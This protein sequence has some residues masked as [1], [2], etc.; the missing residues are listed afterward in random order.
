MGKV[1]TWLL[2]DSP[3]TRLQAQLGRV[4]RDVSALL[5]DPIAST[6]L[7]I[8][9]LM[10]GEALLATFLPV[11]N[12][13]FQALGDRLQPPS[14]AH[15]FGTDT[16]GRDIFSRVLS[17]ARPT[18]S[19]VACVLAIVL[20]FGVLV[21]ITA[22]IFERLDAP[23]MRLCDVFMAF[24]R[25]VLAIAVAVT[26]GPG[27]S[28]AIIAIAL[29]GWPS[30]ARIARAEAVA[31]RRAEFVQAAQV[32]GASP[33]RI[34]FTHILP[35]CLPSAI[36]RATLDASSIIL[37][38]SGLGFLG[39]SVPP[40]QAEWGAMVAEGRD[41]I[42]EAWWVSTMPGIAILT[43]A[44]GFNLLGDALRNLVDPRS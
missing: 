3:N 9:A 33:T 21:G 34:M 8:V 19:I 29:T 37:I 15:W 32:I 39:A 42:F 22:G 16:L 40:P 36:V 30:Y 38:T 2:D 20:P 12:P 5:H 24:P 35:L 27:I 14:A 1:K 41:V 23:I 6:G 28:T 26:L 44:L 25:L 11:Q 17:G 31:L 7:L 43:F 10:V 4:T 18:L 13:G